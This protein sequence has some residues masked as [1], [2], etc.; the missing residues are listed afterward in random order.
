MVPTKIP[1]SSIVSR[2]AAIKK[3]RPFSLTSNFLSASSE[4]RPEIIFPQRLS[5][6]LSSTAP[7]GKAVY[8]GAKASFSLRRIVSTCRSGLLLSKT[9]VDADRGVTIFL[10]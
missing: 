1:T 5:R 2:A 7:P 9:T 6:S 10:L 8:P 4:V 3:E